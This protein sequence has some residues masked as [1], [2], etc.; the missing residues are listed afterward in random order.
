MTA[1]AWHSLLAFFAGVLLNFTPCVLPVLPIKIQAVL[2]ETGSGARARLLAAV[3]LTCGSLLVFIVL[4]AATAWLGLTWGMLFQSKPF[5]VCLTGLLLLAAGATLCDWTFNLPQFIYRI[6]MHRHMGAFFTGALA[7]ILSTPC[8]G[9]FLG[10]VLAYTATREPQVVLAVFIAI[11]AGLA[12]PHVVLIMR[13]GLLNAVSQ[14]R[15]WVVLVKQLLGLVILAGAVFFGRILFPTEW[16]S[17]IW[18]LFCVVTALWLFWTVW[19]IPVRK[20]RRVLVSVVLAVLL[21][22]AVSNLFW[23]TTEINIHWQ[24]F[25]RMALHQAVNDRQQVLIEFTA[26]W[27]LNCKVLEQTV[28]AD[29]AFLQAAMG[30][31]LVALRVDMTDYN[32]DQKS[33]LEKYGGTALPFAVLLDGRG[34]VV[35]RFA[36]MFTAHRLTKALH[37]TDDTIF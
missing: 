20:R 7:G 11:G 33:L 25:T 10:S 30:T 8:S 37:R 18:A 24:A 31:G 26:D 9:P 27:C 4:G 5:L 19:R 16:R 1:L 34:T 13:P 21:G 14:A 23:Y 35:Q 12:F 2:R 6:P 36:G 3:M 17:V 15:P 29:R 22:L 32:D 28:Y